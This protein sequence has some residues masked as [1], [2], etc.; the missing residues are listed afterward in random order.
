MHSAPLGFICFRQ[1]VRVYEAG[2]LAIRRMPSGAVLGALDM[3][4]PINGF[5]TCQ[6]HGS[7]ENA[8]QQTIHHNHPKRRV[9][10]IGDH[11]SILRIRRRNSRFN[12]RKGD[13][14][15]KHPH[16]R[17]HPR[18]CSSGN[19]SYQALDCL[20]HHRTWRRPD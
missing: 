16:D 9:P 10:L 17:S 18:S 20:Q 3:T 5:G 19:P 12:Y 13:C 1:A 7:L 2:R 15:K 8:D 14:K 6:V 4:T 11:F